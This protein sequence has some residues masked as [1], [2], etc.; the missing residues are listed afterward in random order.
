MSNSDAADASSGYQ[1]FVEPKSS[2]PDPVEEERKIS[3]HHLRPPVTDDEP[4]TDWIPEIPFKNV[5]IPD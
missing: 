1:K 5:G 3:K 2:I 4:T